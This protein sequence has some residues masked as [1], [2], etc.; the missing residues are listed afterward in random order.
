MN[1]DARLTAKEIL[2]RMTSLTSSMGSFQSYLSNVCKTSAL[3][4]EQQSQVVA[5]LDYLCLMM[6]ALLVLQSVTE[7]SLWTDVSTLYKSLSTHWRTALV[8]L[9]MEVGAMETPEGQA[10]RELFDD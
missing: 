6:E 3:S 7:R 9:E 1:E 5:T 4:P 8:N 10:L 2:R